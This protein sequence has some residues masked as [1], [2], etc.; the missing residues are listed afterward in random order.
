MSSKRLK[1][2]IL[3]IGVHPDDVELGCSG[4]LLQHIKQGK[5]VGLLDLTKGEL[6]SRG[7]AVIRTEEAMTSAKLLKAECR[8]QLDM[9]DGFFEHNREN[10]LQIIEVIRYTRPEIV[11]A[12]AF[13]DRHPDHGRAGKLIADACFLAGLSK[14]KTT[15]KNH[16]QEKWRPQNVF[17]YLQDYHL[18]PAFVFDIT[19]VI[20]E[21]MALILAYKSQ[22]FDPNST[23]PQTPI[24]GKDFLDFIKARAQNLGR[25]SGFKYA[26]GFQSAKTPGIKD[27][28]NLF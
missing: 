10:L 4:T 19:E 17:H 8:I 18:E 9:A 27:L 13:S 12:N 25:P 22:F 7:S 14:I 21:K 24:S 6:G 15:Y 11:L 26:E 16:L 3:A 23:A 2:D 28:F 1:V 20:E 5:K